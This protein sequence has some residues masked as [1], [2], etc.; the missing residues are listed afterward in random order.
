M[1]EHTRNLTVGLTVLVAIGMLGGMILFFAGLP[2]VFRPGWKLRM[3]FPVSGGV[4]EGDW[5]HLSGIPVGKVTE[6]AFLDG[7]ARKGVLVVARLDR[8]TKI[9][10]TVRPEIVSSGFGRPHIGL[11]TGGRKQI[12]PNSVDGAGFL[13]EQWEGVLPGRLAVGGALS[14]AAE[15]LTKLA[16]TLNDLLAPEAP[17]TAAATGPA[18][19]QTASPAPAG[20]RATLAK[21][22]RALGGMAAIFGSEKNQKNLEQTLTNVAALTEDGVGTMAAIKSFA[23]EASAVAD[24]ARRTLAGAGDVMVDASKAA[25]QFATLAEH[26]D[27][28]VDEISQ[29]LIED[30]EGLSK[31]LSS[32]NRVVTKVEAGQGTAGQL[33]NDPELYRNLLEA[34]QKL[35]ALLKELRDLAEHWKKHGLP[36]KLVK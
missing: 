21:L 7:D 8:G 31:L 3:R 19:T 14:E 16:E 12:D 6:I 32:L 28:R 23:E 11:A 2:E 10:G 25:T 22:D 30:A 36:L 9:P 1:R 17:A 20:L 18:A 4:A 24:E 15:G 34:S 29:K 33:L 13:R 5:V 35:T 27:E 26:A